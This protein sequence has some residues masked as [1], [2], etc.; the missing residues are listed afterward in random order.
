MRSLRIGVIVTLIRVLKPHP[1]R[2]AMSWMGADALEALTDV[3]PLPLRWSHFVKVF[4]GFLSRQ[5]DG[6]FVLS[7]LTSRIDA[8]IVCQCMK[9]NLPVW[10]RL[11][12]L[13]TIGPRIP[14][15]G[16]DD[17]PGGE[18]KVFAV[19]WDPRIVA[20]VS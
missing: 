4:N 6:N 7:L 8:V 5:F 19:G 10:K 2:L 3:D 15:Y 14:A 9:A 11:R 13:K 16:R 1:L 17:V 12:D 20:E 18:G